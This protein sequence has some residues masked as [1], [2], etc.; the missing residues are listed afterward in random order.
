[1]TKEFVLFRFSVT[2]IRRNKQ[3]MPSQDERQKK[4]KQPLR[5]LNI[6]AQ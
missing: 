1:M 6:T 4:T 3:Q 5:K 2:E